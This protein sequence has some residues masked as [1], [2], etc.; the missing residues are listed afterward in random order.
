MAARRFFVQGHVQGVGFRYFTQE[1]ARALGLSGYVRNLPD[2]RVEAW[3]E[4]NHQAIEKLHGQ[5]LEGPP[6]ARVSDVI[7]EEA[8]PT[9]AYDSFRITR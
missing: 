4:G 6:G 7:A 3:V 9:G 1:A 8:E 2:G 5:I